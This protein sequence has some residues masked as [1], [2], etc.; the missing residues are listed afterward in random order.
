MNRAG[1]IRIPADAGRGLAR[2]VVAL[3]E[4]VRE[5]LERQ[6]VRRMMAGSLSPDQTER[7]GQ[8]LLALERQLAELREA[9]GVDG[10][11]DDLLPLD[12][13]NLLTE[14]LPTQR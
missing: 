13:A 11:T 4:I 3:L 9:L 7:L 14:E 8:S 10:S 2:L 1:D 6:A 12:L 5:L